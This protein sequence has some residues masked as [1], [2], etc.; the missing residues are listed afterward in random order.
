MRSIVRLIVELFEGSF[1]VHQTEPHVGK[2]AGNEKESGR[3]LWGNSERS[4]R[5]NH[6]RV[7]HGVVVV[8]SR[9]T[10]QQIA[11]N[12]RP[13]RTSSSKGKAI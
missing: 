7:V 1:H 6:E 13:N 11:G 3:R 5:S 9:F 2:L 10:H 8:R 4:P 12:R